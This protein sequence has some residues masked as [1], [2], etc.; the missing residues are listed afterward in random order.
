MKPDPQG[1]LLDLA[2]LGAWGGGGGSSHMKGTLGACCLVLEL[3][4][5]LF[6]Y[7]CLGKNAYQI[8]LAVM[9]SFRFLDEEID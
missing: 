4:G 7:G 5:F 3:N 6:H 1:P 9:V 2:L 8:F